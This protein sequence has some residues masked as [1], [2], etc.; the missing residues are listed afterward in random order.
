MTPFLSGFQVSET[1]E[2]LLGDVEGG[3]EA[4]AIL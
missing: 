2:R 4:A 3:S 1:R